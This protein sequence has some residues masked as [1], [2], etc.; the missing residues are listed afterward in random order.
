MKEIDLRLILDRVVQGWR[1]P[2]FLVVVLIMFALASLPFQR[3]VYSVRMTVVPAPSEHSDMGGSSNAL[4]SL[5]SFGGMAAGN[6]N[7]TRYQ[8]L[9]VSTVV[10]QRMQEKYGMLQYVFSSMWNEKEKTWVQP[11]TLQSTML[12]WLFKLAHV[13]VWS[14]PDVTT[15][16]DYL[17]TNL[18]ITPSTQNDIVVVTMNSSDVKFAKRV[19]L[20]AHE[21]ANAVLRDQVARRAKQQVDYLQTKLRETTVQDYRATLL[22]ILSSQE[23]TLMLTQT[24][25]SFAAEILAPPVASPTPTS[26]R[27]VLSIFVAAL[28]GALAGMA[29]VIF[30]GP[31]WWRTAYQRG[32]ATITALRT[33]QYNEAVAAPRR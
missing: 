11:R 2:V 28:V 22:T 10:A 8:K 26:P 31:D 6:N 33:G 16:A 5:L 29:L 19:M 3:P 27:P 14:P 32:A 18:L 4:T 21:Q 24:D 7:Y 25:A 9:L 23:K 15:L 17:G 20:A 30:F 13:P 1:T 12:G